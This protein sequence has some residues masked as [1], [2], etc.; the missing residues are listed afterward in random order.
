LPGLLVKAEVLRALIAPLMQEY[1]HLRERGYARTV[2]ENLRMRSVWETMGD[3]YWE[4]QPI[5][6]RIDNILADIPRRIKQLRDDRG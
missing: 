5:Q 4:L 2:E 6:V 3:L 1:Q